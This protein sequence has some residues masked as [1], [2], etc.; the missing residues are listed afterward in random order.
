MSNDNN[1]LA[2]MM[3]DILNGGSGQSNTINSLENKLDSILAKSNNQFIS[4]M[5]EG[6]S[7]VGLESFNKQDE[8]NDAKNSEDK[9]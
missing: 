9:K 3:D 1:D 5:N 2:N 6:S 8:S 7:L 4:M